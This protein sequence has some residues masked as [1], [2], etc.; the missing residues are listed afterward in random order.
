MIDKDLGEKIEECLE[1]LFRLEKSQ[2]RVKTT[3]LAKKLGS[4]LSS[5]T[6]LLQ[7]LSKMGLVYYEPYKGVRLT[8]KGRKVA[9]KIIR[10]HR[11]S[12]RFLTDIL[13]LDWCEVHEHAC[14]LEHAITDKVEE[15]LN[16]KLGGPTV[17]PHGN[18]IPTPS[19]EIIFEED[20][21]LSELQPA[22]EAIITRITDENPALLR[23]L[24]AIGIL[25]GVKITVKEKSP[26][27]GALVLKIGDYEV[28]LGHDVASKI[29]AKTSTAPHRHRRRMRHGAKSRK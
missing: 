15:K 3:E 12:E 4:P 29:C 27:G 24:I 2:K 26:L 17:C 5:M 14:K 6:V 10:R 1:I 25:P 13:G 23:R 28:A 20:I 8:D 7:R 16:E 9:I 11:L 21:P 22:E 18:P 19:G